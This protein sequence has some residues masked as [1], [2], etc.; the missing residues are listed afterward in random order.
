MQPLEYVP[1]F[2][3]AH[4]FQHHTAN[5]RGNIQATFARQKSN[6]HAPIIEVLNFF[7]QRMFRHNMHATHSMP[8]TDQS[9]NAITAHFCELN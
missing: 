7:P 9:L 8:E 6:L 5:Q 3:H 2:T 4:D 1:L